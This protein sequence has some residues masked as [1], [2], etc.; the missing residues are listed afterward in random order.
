M[1]TTASHL[2]V[3]PPILEPCRTISAMH[4]SSGTPGGPM[5]VL[6]GDW[7]LSGFVPRS[8]GR[9]VTTVWPYPSRTSVRSSESVR[10]HIG[11]SSADAA[12]D[13]VG[14][15]TPK[16]P[17]SGSHSSTSTSVNRARENAVTGRSLVCSSA[18]RCRRSSTSP[19]V[20]QP[21]HVIHSWALTCS[22]SNRLRRLSGSRFLML[23]FILLSTTAR[24]DASAP[25]CSGGVSTPSD[26]V[27]ATCGNPLPIP[28]GEAA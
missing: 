10:S 1:L 3:G 25:V 28:V 24:G 14:V 6:G 15:K 19:R 22:R 27:V 23:C 5:S 8:V 12:S 4:S 26:L 18:H 16:S 9:S 21:R 7:N 17:S 13:V 11:P 20:A 2:P